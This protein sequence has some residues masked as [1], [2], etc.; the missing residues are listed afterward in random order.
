MSAL[1]VKVIILLSTTASCSAE[2]LIHYVTPNDTTPC[3]TGYRCDTIMGYYDKLGSQ[4]NVTWIFLEGTHNIFIPGDSTISN[5]T[6]TSVSNVVWKG[7]HRNG[8]LI[9]FKNI[10]FIIR[11]SSN[12]SFQDLGIRG[13]NLNVLFF[14]F[15]TLEGKLNFSIENVSNL[16]MVNVTLEGF[17][18][19]FDNTFGHCW[20]Q[21]CSL[22]DNDILIVGTEK[23]EGRRLISI[24]NTSLVNVSTT[25]QIDQDNEYLLPRIQV[26]ECSYLYSPIHIEKITKLQS[27]TMMCK[28]NRDKFVQF[29]S[30]TFRGKYIAFGIKEV[31]SSV[32]IS[33]CTFSGTNRGIALKVTN[34][35]IH[36][37]GCNYIINNKN[38]NYQ[39]IMTINSSLVFL[40]KGAVLTISNNEALLSGGLVYF[41]PKRENSIP[42]IRRGITSIECQQL[43]FIQLV[44]SE[45]TFLNE[46]E[47]TRF[48]GSIQL[49]NNNRL[50]GLN[51][52]QIFAGNLLNCT[53]LLNNANITADSKLLQKLIHLPSWNSTDIATSPQAICLCIPDSYDTS[54]LYNKTFWDCSSY[55]NITIY[56]GNDLKLHVT[57]MGQFD[58]SLSK[59][60]VATRNESIIRL[61]V[62]TQCTPLLIEANRF[63]QIGNIIVL[64]Q[65]DENDAPQIKHTLKL[66]TDCPNGFSLKPDRR[67]FLICKGCSNFLAKNKFECN[68]RFQHPL[69]KQVENK[70]MGLHNKTLILADYC[71]LFYCTEFLRTNGVYQSDLNT[72]KQCNPENKRQGFLCS[73]CPEGHS[74]TFGGFQCRKCQTLWLL[75]LIIY[76]LAGPALLAF[77]FLFNFTIVQGTINGI[78]IYANVMYLYD[79]FLQENARGIFYAIISFLNFGSGRNI[80]F[81]DG[82]DEFSNAIL[83]YAFPMYLI[84]LGILIILGAQ[85]L[86]LKLFRVQ[87]II[88]RCV[89][90]LATVMILT[91]INFVEVIWITLRFTSVHYLRQQAN[92]SEFEIMPVTK[93][94]WLYQP[95]LG[96]LQGKH[97]FL[98]LIAVIISVFYIL[99][100]TIVVLFGDILR[101]RC[102]RKMWFSHFI[103][104]FQGAYRRPFGFWLGLRLILRI[105]L[106]SIQSLLKSQVLFAYITL[107]IVLALLCLENLLKPFRNDISTL[108]RSYMLKF[109]KESLTLKEELK[110]CFQQII[111]PLVLDNISLLNVICF[112]I[113]IIK[114]P[115][116]IYKVLACTISVIAI[117]LLII[118]VVVYHGYLYFPIPKSVKM[119]CKKS[120]IHPPHQRP[121]REELKDT[122][123]N[124]KDDFAIDDVFPFRDIE[125]LEVNPSKESDSSEDEMY[126][127]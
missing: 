99:P 102:I 94:V 2:H 40:E 41:P 52:N 66:A 117:V 109:S 121:S 27:P 48:N 124:E 24:T 38:V 86:K 74:S 83:Q 47:I 59:L 82:M 122:A 18:I 92:S 56:P 50:Q 98:G 55:T 57:I 36:L 120:H 15:R 22:K 13:V 111:H 80:C 33:N 97:L 37:R 93:K 53:L 1:T 77:L 12:I 118:F 105:G 58:S 115:D 79:D 63:D 23:S 87:F 89:P 20:I 125:Y 75:L 96:Y 21:T 71:P 30:S 54:I 108:R 65:S 39:G 64:I 60:Q 73:E 104:V 7:E 28:G 84:F 8:S 69:Y 46:S 107:H 126:F 62:T 114:Q 14:F 44:D 68:F 16:G 81:Y 106:V 101:R 6:M 26:V 95:I 17:Q 45:G 42:C 4:S 85:V 76:T 9:N 5:I 34:A 32:L 70:W 127:T 72:N 43:C 112:S 119:K 103:D 67:G 10:N 31:C 19:K 123:N 113:V 78:I 61:D 49:F 11:N 88:K 110:I 91:Y 25:I 116:R 35:T 90:V 3:N 51:G 100:L 29:S